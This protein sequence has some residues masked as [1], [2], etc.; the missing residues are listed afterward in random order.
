M[1]TAIST[2]KISKT[3]NGQTIFR[4]LDLT[5]KQGC[6]TAIVGPN[7]AGKSTLFN[8]IAGIVAQD[9]GHITIQDFDR[10]RFSYVFQSY[11]ESLLPWKTN[12]EN[13][14]FPLQIQGIN[15]KERKLRVQQLLGRHGLE[16]LAEGY[17]YELSGG[18]QQMLALMRAL[19]TQPKIL[20]LDEP[21]SALDYE[22]TLRM[23]NIL[24]EYYL[25]TK[26][27]IFI[28][29]HDIEEAVYLASRIT[30]FSPKPTRVIKE[31]NNQLTYPRTLE[32]LKSTI[33]HEIT[34]EVLESFRQ[35]VRLWTV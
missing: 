9:S 31:I 10:F 14:A 30:I 6:I 35:T 28:I 13:I 19:I 4:E 33:F 11:R 3:Y 8:L 16:L 26:A 34:N 5:V 18:Q 17:P 22:N 20:L 24:Q 2:K 27:T 32:T 15:L 23:R 12:V 25:A 29:T 7:G 21:F 1:A